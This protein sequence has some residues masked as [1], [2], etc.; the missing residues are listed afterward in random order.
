[1]HTCLLFGWPGRFIVLTSLFF[2]CLMDASAQ[3]V[4]STLTAHTLRLRPGQDLKQTLDAWLTTHRVQ[5]GTMLT[6]VGSLTEVVLRL[7]NQDGPTRYSG[8]FE[9]VSLVG[10]L[11]VNGS[12]LH[13]SVSDSTGRTVGGHLLA[14]NLVYTTA[15][16]VIGV[17]PDVMFVREPDPA[18]GYRELVVQPLVKNKKQ[19]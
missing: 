19:K 15:E 16:L 3:S 1:M 9:I 6:G 4:P 11:S 5:A 10:T 13:L 14:G 17:L 8:H 2:L 12:H 7:A 18:F